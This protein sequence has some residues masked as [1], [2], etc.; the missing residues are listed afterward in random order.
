MDRLGFWPLSN[1][2]AL[3]YDLAAVGTLMLAAWLIITG[4]RSGS[5]ERT[6]ETK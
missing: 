4:L 3:G 2:E 5:S 1:S 6:R